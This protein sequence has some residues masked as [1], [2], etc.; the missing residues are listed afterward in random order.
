MAIANDNVLLRKLH[1]KIGNMII[2]GWGKKTV[3]SKAPDYKKIKWSKA[4]IENRERFGKASLKVNEKL[5]DDPELKKKYKKLAKGNQNAHNV[6][7]SDYLKPPVI[8]EINVKNY[9]GQKGNTIRVGAKDKYFVAGLI[10]MILNA[11]GIEVES[12]MAVEMPFSGSGVWIYK[13]MEDNKR[14]KG[15]KVVV[16]VAD[17]PGNVVTRT[18]M[19]DGT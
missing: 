10:V 17:L 13:A 7:M 9:K 11:Q 6:A 15:G 14:W 4:Q 3:A 16:R 5:R 8:T 19:L 12:G 1:G 2:R 18:L